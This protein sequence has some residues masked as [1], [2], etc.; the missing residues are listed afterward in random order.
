MNDLKFSII[1]FLDDFYPDVC[2]QYVKNCW[3]CL[4]TCA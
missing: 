3:N 1:V 4:N 2:N